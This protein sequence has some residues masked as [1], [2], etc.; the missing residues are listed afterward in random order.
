[1]TDPPDQNSRSGSGDSPAHAVLD[2]A[3]KTPPAFSIARIW[4]LVMSTF[5]QLVRMKTFYFLFFF[6]VI[7]FGVGQLNLV[8]TPIQK[9]RTI[10]EASLGV[11]WVFSWLFAIAATALLIPRD[12]EDRT[13]Y[14]IL[15]KPVSRLEYL[16]GKLGGVLLTIGVSLLVMHLLYAVVLGIREAIVI[17]AE[18]ASLANDSRFSPEEREATLDL[19]RAYGLHWEHLYATLAIFLQ[20]SI[21]ATITLLISTFASSTLFSMIIS[22][23]IFVVGHF[24]KLMD[25]YIFQS[26]GNILVSVLVKIILL[27]I[28]DFSLFDLNL[29]ELVFRGETI[30]IG[31]MGE[32]FG[33]SVLYV[34]VYLSAS[35]YLFVDKEF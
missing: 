2:T 30:P 5:T 20:A 13:L 15:A 19:V 32:L 7:A 6:A 27:V 4:T 1:M 31:L 14:T 18:E 9:L 3:A 16:L 21:V 23:L 11:M 33:L 10:T 17:S 24:A 25:F 34:G 22:V 12:I 35:L 8:Y 26:G 29:A 28:P